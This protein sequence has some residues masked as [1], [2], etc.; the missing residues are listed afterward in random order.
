MYFFFC[1]SY[2]NQKIDIKQNLNV[3]KKV[4]RLEEVSKSMISDADFEIV[5]KKK[6]KLEGS[7]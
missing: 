6:N 4:K 3:T 1:Y 5:K 7:P 2:N